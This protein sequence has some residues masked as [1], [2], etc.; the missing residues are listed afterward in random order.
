MKFVTGNHQ[1]GLAITAKAWSIKLGLLITAKLVN[2]SY[3]FRA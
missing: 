3:F 1:A 2:Q